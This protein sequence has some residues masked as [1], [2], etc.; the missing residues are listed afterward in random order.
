[1]LGRLFEKRHPNMTRLRMINK[2]LRPLLTSFRIQVRGTLNK[3]VDRFYV[4]LI[5][6]YEKKDYFNDFTVYSNMLTHL[7]T[8]SFS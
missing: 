4:V 5:R 8:L 1:M 3:G 7:C 2:I 6:I